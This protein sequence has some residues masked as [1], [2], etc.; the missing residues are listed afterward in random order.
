MTQLIS[1]VFRS[2]KRSALTKEKYRWISRYGGHFA[3]QR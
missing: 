2:I 1:E 3:N